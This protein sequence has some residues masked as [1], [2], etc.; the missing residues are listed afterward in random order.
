MKV[1]KNLMFVM[2]AVSVLVGCKGNKNDE[3]DNPLQLENERLRAD[4]QAK[5]ST[6]NALFASYNEIEENLAM[7]KEK[8]NLIRKSGTGDLSLDAKQRIATDLQLIAD[9]MEKNKQSIASLR[10]R[11]KES[12]LKL[13]ELDKTIAMLTKTIEDKDAEILTLSNQLAEKNVELKTLAGQIQAISS[14]LESKAQALSQKEDELNKA[15]YVI[16]TERELRDKGIVT[17]EGGF[18][19]I[20]KTRSLANDFS[21]KHFTEMD[22]RKVKSIPINQRSAKIVTIHPTNSYNLVGDQSVE[23]LEIVDA[24]SFW[25]TSKHLVIVVK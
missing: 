9:L 23:R 2:L 25:R 11:V 12:D 22:I 3:Q 16:G 24:A 5:D 8:E 4:Y 21:A 1:L 20:G 13:S 17:R 7:I 18:V 10:R 19:G 14:D 6:L 15:W